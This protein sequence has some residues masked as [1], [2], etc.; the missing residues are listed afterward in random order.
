L[1]WRIF[2]SAVGYLT[3][4]IGKSKRSASTLYVELSERTEISVVK[5]DVVWITASF[6]P[7]QYFLE[8]IVNKTDNDQRRSKSWLLVIFV[9]YTESMETP[10]SLSVLLHAIERVTTNTENVL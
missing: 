7:L 5:M 10:N 1:R 6:H 4:T 9:N 3:L 2:W 8:D